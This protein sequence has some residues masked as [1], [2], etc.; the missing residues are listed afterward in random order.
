MLRI[1]SVLQ[2]YCCLYTATINSK[3]MGVPV[4]IQRLW[5]LYCPLGTGLW[6]ALQG[7]GRSCKEEWRETGSLSLKVWRL[8]RMPAVPQPVCL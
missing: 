7:P 1:F 5:S 3:H 4:Q 2:V 6:S 8:D